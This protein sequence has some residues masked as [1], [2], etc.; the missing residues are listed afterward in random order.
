MQ[1]LVHVQSNEEII[2]TEMTYRPVTS[3]TFEFSL[4]GTLF[5]V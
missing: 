4:A 3:S 5:L 1:Y 2:T